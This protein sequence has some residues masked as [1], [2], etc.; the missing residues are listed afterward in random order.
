[1]LERY[2]RAFVFSPPRVCQSNICGSNGDIYNIIH[3]IEPKIDYCTKGPIP[4]SIKLLKEKASGEFWNY[5]M[6]VF[7][8]L[9]KNYENEHVSMLHSRPSNL[10]NNLFPVFANPSRFTSFIEK[11]TSLYRTIIHTHTTSTCFP[12][13]GIGATSTMHNK[14]V[15]HVY[16]IGQSLQN[17]ATLN[18]LKNIGCG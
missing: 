9:V 14:G 4:K 15:S 8:K 2:R 10:M 17:I 5:G 11:P 6:F 18:L 12:I 1:M 7:K 13:V 16:L 3:A